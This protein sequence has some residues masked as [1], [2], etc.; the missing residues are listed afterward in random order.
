MNQLNFNEQVLQSELPVL[1]DYCAKGIGVRANI[2]DL[3][4]LIQHS[5]LSPNQSSVQDPRNPRL[6]PAFRS[7]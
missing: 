7:P 3:A 4:L 5:C 6:F 1:V 2:R